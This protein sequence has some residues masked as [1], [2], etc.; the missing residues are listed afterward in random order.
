MKKPKNKAT[1]LLFQ[2]MNE[3]Y[4]Q[5]QIEALLETIKWFKKEIGPHD[6]GWM[7]TTIDG[8]KVRIKHLR[9]EMRKDLSKKSWIDEYREWKK[10]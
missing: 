4:K 10:K 8:L 5:Q 6:C 9:S 2:R 1:H 7:Y 3:M